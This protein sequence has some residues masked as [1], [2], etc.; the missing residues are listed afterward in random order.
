MTT[1]VDDMRRRAK[2]GRLDAVWSHLTADTSEELHAFAQSIGLH[3]EWAQKEGTRREHY[4]VTEPKRQEAMRRGAIAISYL[5]DT[6]ALLRSKRSTDDP[7]YAPFM[8][9]G[10]GEDS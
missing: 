3:R 5:R 2:V 9:S 8:P 7:L 1:Y 6:E 10:R 4:D